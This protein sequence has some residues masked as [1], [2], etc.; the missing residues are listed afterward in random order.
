M[1]LYEFE[2]GN[3]RK[4]FELLVPSAKWKGA[5]CPHCGSNKLSKKLSVFAS[6]VAATGQSAAP[7]QQTVQKTF[8]VRL[9]RG[10]DRPVRGGAAGL[11]VHGPRLRLL[12]SHPP[13]LS[14]AFLPWFNT[15]GP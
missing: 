11:P 8:R 10:R 2:C 5:V 15:P 12:R 9:P 3:C 14:G 13:A 1:P 7:P 6:H 4:E